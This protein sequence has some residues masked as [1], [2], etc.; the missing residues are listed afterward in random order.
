MLEPKIRLVVDGLH[1]N[2]EGYTQVENILTSRYGKMSEAVNTHVQAIMTL[3]IVHG[4]N[5]ISIHEFYEKLLTH[6]QSL[7]TMGKLI[8]IEK[9]VRNTL[10]SIPQIRSNLVRLDGEW[11]QW[12]FPKLIDALRQWVERN[13]VTEI[14]KE[15]PPIR[16]DKNFNTRQQNTT[17][18]KCVLCDGTGHRINDC[19]GVKDPVKRRHI[20]S[21]KKL[22]FNCLK[23]GHCAADC[24]SPTCFKCNRKHHKHCLSTTN[25]KEAPTTE[26]KRQKK[27]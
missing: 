2:T 21:S 10:D 12:D 15:K 7:E 25:Y 5:P 6:V 1:F 20:V 14:G 19:T 17:D 9:Y 16:R 24:P 11:Q 26:I 27:R 23:Y 13:P 8:T 18:R 22:C 4:S 3:Q